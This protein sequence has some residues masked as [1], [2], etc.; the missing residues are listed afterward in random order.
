MTET[1]GSGRST[2]LQIVRVI[3]MERIMG[4]VTMTGM[5]MA[6]IKDGQKEKEIKRKTSIQDTMINYKNNVIKNPG[7]TGVF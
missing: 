6:N 3:R 4:I 1:E 7:L 5:I 2:G